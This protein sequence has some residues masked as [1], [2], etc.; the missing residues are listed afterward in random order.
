MNRSI[1]HEISGWGFIQLK[2]AERV[3]SDKIPKTCLL[4]Y[5]YA[6]GDIVDVQSCTSFRGLGNFGEHE[7]FFLVVKEAI[8]HTIRMRHTEWVVRIYFHVVIEGLDWRVVARNYSDHVPV[9]IRQLIQLFQTLIRCRSLGNWLENG[10]RKITWQLIAID[11]QV[12]IL[13]ILNLLNNTQTII[14]IKHTFTFR[15]PWLQWNI[16]AVFLNR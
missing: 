2:N 14:R 8:H 5:F 10:P 6:I 11:L 7:S 13:I 1:N 3:I 12:H 4:C 9:R 16:N 15:R